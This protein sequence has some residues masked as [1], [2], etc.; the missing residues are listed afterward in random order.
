MSRFT[1]LVCLLLSSFS[2]ALLSALAFDSITARSIAVN[3]RA[4]AAKPFLVDAI[5]VDHRS[6][7]SGT[8]L[9]AGLGGG[10]G[11]SS[12]I[13][14]SGGNSVRGRNS[15]SPVG[16]NRIGVVTVSLAGGKVCGMV[17]DDWVCERTRVLFSF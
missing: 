6:D 16:S 12:W 17:G 2:I 11:T 9:G 5:R 15:S 10:T 8:G 4:P 7:T 13:F 3:F 14:G 1:S